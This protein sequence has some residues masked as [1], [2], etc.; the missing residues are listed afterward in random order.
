MIGLTVWKHFEGRGQS[1]AP[2]LTILSQ[3]LIY[4]KVLIQV[5]YEPLPPT[6]GQN[7]F[8][9]QVC[10]LPGLFCYAQH[11]ASIDGRRGLFTG[12][13]PRLCSGVLGTVVHGKVLQVRGKRWMFAYILATFYAVY[14]TT[15]SNFK[16]VLITLAWHLFLLKDIFSLLIN[17]TIE[18]SISLWSID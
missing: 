17:W 12:L 10:Q 15:K 8:G 5:G 4:V 3:P 1:G 18:D 6:I 9:R 11:I 7:I 16:D 13:T 14:S 2:G